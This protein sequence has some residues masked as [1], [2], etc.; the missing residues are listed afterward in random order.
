M[1]SS[2]TALEAKF[3]DSLLERGERVV[4]AVSGGADSMVLLERL[5]RLRDVLELELHVAHVNY[6]L[7]GQASELDER[8]VRRR[9]HELGLFL[10]VHRTDEVRRAS[11]GNL[12]ERARDVRYK[13]FREVAR[14]VGAS[15][16][17]LGHTQDDQVET[18]LLRLM[19]GSGLTGLVAMQPRQGQLVR[20][21]LN[22]SRAEVRAY[23]HERGIPHRL[24]A[25]NRDLRFA[26][27]RVRHLLLPML[28]RYFNQQ[29]KETLARSAELVTEDEHFLQEL[30]EKMYGKLV[31]ERRDGRDGLGVE[32]SIK[33][34][35]LTDLPLAL[36]RRLVRAMSRAAAP[37]VQLGHGIALDQ[38]LSTLAAHGDGV[39]LELGDRLTM[40]RKSG[41][42][43]ITFS[44]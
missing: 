15:A 39:T 35:E 23:A 10:H 29:I 34:D 33:S 43:R 37:K 24:D 27:N 7:R 31:K 25:S 19:R 26:R 14:E 38:A 30:T 40:T 11:S 42:V 5:A 8:L 41:T 21:L 12:E 28:E 44:T 22:L 36:Q 18:V 2:T 32:V 1:R 17:A 6:G 20:P 3:A 13:Y 4:V 9:C 16:I